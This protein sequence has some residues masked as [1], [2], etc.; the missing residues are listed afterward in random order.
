MLEMEKRISENVELTKQ[1]QADAQKRRQ[2]LERRLD[3]DEDDD[4]DEQ[5]KLNSA[6][7][8]VDKQSAVLERHLEDCGVIFS[9]LHSGRTGVVIG[10]VKTD[11]F[12]QAMLALPESVIGRINARIGN[13]ST[14]DHS[15]TFIG[16]YKGDFAPGDF[17]KNPPR[18]SPQ[19]SGQTCG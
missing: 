5:S 8:E 17:F 19:T 3:E 1:Q 11:K 15:S 18:P 7:G 6:L 10:D 2:D 16:V 9:Q 13:V 14:T 4:D 12:S